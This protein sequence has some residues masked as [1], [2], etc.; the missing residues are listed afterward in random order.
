[1]FKK[2][3]AIVLAVALTFGAT[4]CVKRTPTSETPVVQFQ[5]TLVAASDATDLVASSLQTVDE[6]R[7]ALAGKGQ[8]TPEQSASLLGY[9]K[10]IAGK[11]EAAV[12][13]INLAETA[14]SGSTIGWTTALVDVST[15][16]KSIDPALFGIKN[17]DAQATLRV[18]LSVLDVA[19]Q[20][21]D[22]SF[23]GK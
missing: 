3:S 13:A 17:S 20:T 7:K 23:G 2:L 22:A 21:I 16:I 5:R 11:N 19:A 8:I 14:G 4:S 10:L 12:Q 15:T 18:A 9:L 6:A 1:M